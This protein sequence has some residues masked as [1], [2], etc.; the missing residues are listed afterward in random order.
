MQL[1]SYSLQVEVCM[2]HCA[3]ASLTHPQAWCSNRKPPFL[4]GDDSKP[5]RTCSGLPCVP[6]ANAA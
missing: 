6:V 5:V 1:H 4:K 2:M 3:T